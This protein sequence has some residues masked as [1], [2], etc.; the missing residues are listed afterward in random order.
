MHTRAKIRLFAGE[1]NCCSSFTYYK[2]NYLV[3]NE[4]Y[5][6]GTLKLPFDSCNF[7]TTLVFSKTIFFI[8]NDNYT[9]EKLIK[10]CTGVLC[11]FS[12]V[13]KSFHD[14]KKGSLTVIFK[15]TIFGLSMTY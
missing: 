4:M 7:N 5:R 1:L 13:D 15:M 11:H 2:Y 14:F 3:D 8:T 10:P 12:M 6:K 9:N